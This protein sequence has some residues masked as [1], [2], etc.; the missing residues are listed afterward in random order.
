[1]GM[2]TARA[3]FWYQDEMY[4]RPQNIARHRIDAQH[5]TDASL[6]WSS[7]DQRWSVD[8]FVKNLTDEDN[9]RGM[10]ISDGLS[11]G[12]NTFLSYFPP[13]TY[14]VRIGYTLGGG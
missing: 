2:L 14:G 10:T 1:H 4:M 5:Q 7:V 3:Q 8:A 11:T 13:R 12:N 6:M 9:I